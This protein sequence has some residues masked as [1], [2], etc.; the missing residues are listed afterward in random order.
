[1]IERY[2][3]AVVALGIFAAFSLPRASATDR[4]YADGKAESS[5]GRYQIVATSPDNEGEGLK[6]FADDFTYVLTD[7]KT[8]TKLWQRRQQKDEGAPIFLYVDDDGWVMIRTAWDFLVFVDPAG[9][10]TGKIDL[11]NNVFTE[12][13]KENYMAHTTA[14]TLWSG[15]ALWYPVEAD[16]KRMF[17]L[18]TWWGRRAVADF[19][20]GKLVEDSA[21]QEEH[22]LAITKACDAAEAAM[23]IRCLTEKKPTRA[24]LTAAFWAGKLQLTDALPL[25]K[26]LQDSDYVGSS[27][28]GS[29]VYHP[30]DGEVDPSNWKTFTMRQIVHLSMRQLG[31][32]PDSHH[33]TAFD[34]HFEDY[35]KEYEYRLPELKAPR[36]VGAEK[37]KLGTKP[38]AV[39]AA[40][41]APD[42]N[43]SHW[44]YYEIDS[45]DPFTLCLRWGEDGVAEIKRRRPAYWKSN[46]WDSEVV[47]GYPP[48]LADGDTMTI[49]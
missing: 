39:L 31:E 5:D 14:G 42:F 26:N 9:D 19:A 29:S 30:A 28:S 40:V 46:I 38:E 35:Q 13:E 18:R 44:W 43:S 7:T 8:G 45:E 16:H 11:Y 20:T 32:Q 47:L 27:A 6:P 37:L 2:W 10:E 17:A 21:D 24:A 41:G 22:N 33:C 49:P 15:F 25:L 4:F 34:L 36:I 12:Q 23:V 48:E 1:M 3:S